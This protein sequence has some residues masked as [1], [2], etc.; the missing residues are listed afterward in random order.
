MFIMRLRELAIISQGTRLTDNSLPASVPTGG[1]PSSVRPRNPNQKA[2]WNELPVEVLKIICQHLDPAT[3]LAAR[4]VAVAMKDACSSGAMQLRFTLPM[5]SSQWVPA[6]LEAWERR[7]NCIA[8]LLSSGK[9]VSHEMQ[10]RME[11]AA[12]WKGE[13]NMPPAQVQ[14]AVQR[15]SPLLQS[16]RKLGHQTVTPITHLDVELP[17]T[18]EIIGILNV[19]FPD[20][21][22]LRL[23][24]SIPPPHNHALVLAESH[25]FTN[26]CK[27]DI[28]LTSWD[29]IQYLASLQQLTELRV[30]Y[31]L[32]NI[33]ELTPLA[34]LQNLTT[35]GIE[36]QDD[37]ARFQLDF[38]G[39]LVRGAP[40]LR[41]LRAAII[42]SRTVVSESG[43]ASCD[44]LAGCGLETL[45]LDVRVPEDAARTAHAHFRN[46]HLAPQ[47]CKVY[48]TIR[49]DALT[50]ETSF[51]SAATR[52]ANMSMPRLG[53]AHPSPPDPR[54]RWGALN[55][56]DLGGHARD[57]LTLL[58]LRGY[59]TA[60]STLPDLSAAWLMRLQIS[61]ARLS[62]ADFAVLATCTSLEHLFVRFMYQPDAPGSNTSTTEPVH[63]LSYLGSLSFTRGWG[64]CI[65]PRELQSSLRLVAHASHGMV[66]RS[67]KSLQGSGRR[68]TG[69]TAAAAV[70]LQPD[71]TSQAAPYVLRPLLQL[72]NLRSL[73][74]LEE[75]QS[76]VGPPPRLS[77][78]G[79]GSSG[80]AMP[81]AAVSA[82]AG[83]SAKRTRRGAA[84]KSNAAAGPSAA[85]SAAAQ[86]GPPQPAHT[87]QT[88]PTPTLLPLSRSG[89]DHFLLHLSCLDHLKALSLHFL[90][91]DVDLPDCP[92]RTSCFVPGTRG[93]EPPQPIDS[94]YVCKRLR[95]MDPECY[96]FVLGSLVVQS[97][98]WY[99]PSAWPALES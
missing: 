52:G 96:R 68:S 6:Q 22:S 14:N 73:E 85:T 86:A 63:N 98:I 53:V 66:T 93:K 38:L 8:G 12:T 75:P 34:G 79:A 3:L 47:G 33:P 61:N 44:F 90:T 54:E 1:L 10:L 50:R 78:V 65:R 60:L 56:S 58:H 37:R 16:L 87:P 95:M 99:R 24:C 32:W 70:P 77:A 91:E 20:V 72:Q 19:A 26:V 27:L 48:L 45:D 25:A 28:G 15:L 5:Q 36:V 59:H 30:R 69:S 49:A 29:Q 62:P 92:C 89:L 88:E 71:C 23:D 46:L 76:P 55:M 31:C 97:P 13:E 18:T 94:E 39:P 11:G 80:P 9:M 17:I 74:L 7:V 35:F 42:L 67:R 57:P 82:P 43:P 40:R 21:T 83:A 81:A 51:E 41:H 2:T 64:D 4:R 84:V